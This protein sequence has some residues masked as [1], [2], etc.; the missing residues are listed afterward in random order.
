MQR[1]Y[2]RLR[3]INIV[4][5]TTATAVTRTVTYKIDVTIPSITCP[6]GVTVFGTSTAVS[7]TGN[8]SASD[9]CSVPSAITISSSDGTPVCSSNTSA[10]YYFDRT[11]T[12]TDECG[13]HS[14]CTQRITVARKIGTPCFYA[15][16]ISRTVT[17]VAGK[18]TTTFTYKACT[19][20]NTKCADLSNIAFVAL[21]DLCAHSVNTPT[22]YTATVPVN[23][24][25]S[26]KT[27]TTTWGIK[28]DVNSGA[29]GI[30]Y[31]CQNFTFTLSGDQ[32]ASAITVQFKAGKEAPVSGTATCPTSSTTQSPS[33]T[34]KDWSR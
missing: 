4:S 10:T 9:D 26:G 6:P 27:L 30:K 28:Y 25:Q 31:A 17:T 13:N 20:P 16:L 14:S 32:P 22:G 11:F 12:A 21:T 29:P 34:S 7:A 33:I 19:Q 3:K 23:V 1:F 8:A 15:D 2:I 24:I 18:T 5:F